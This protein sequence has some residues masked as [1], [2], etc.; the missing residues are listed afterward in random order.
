MEKTV[1]SRALRR[2]AEILGGDE[3]L[4]QQLKCSARELDTRLSAVE[5]PPMDVFLKAVDII[6]AAPVLSKP[7]ERARELRQKTDALVAR[8][9][10]A[11]ERSMAIHQAIVERR[12]EFEAPARP[13]SALAF[14]QGKFEPRD[15]PAMVSA[16]LD[17]AV[18]ATGADMGNMQLACPDGLRIVAQ[19]GF[20][21]PFLDFFSL[22]AEPRCAC[23]AAFGTGQRVAIADVRSDALF[24]GTQ[25][26]QVVL[27]AGALAVQ[28]TPVVG[29]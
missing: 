24:A 29:A 2:A 17:A 6:S 4:R 28:S 7:A 14:L 10:A 8:A 9:A 27:D 22:V 18:A 1:Q 19:R 11:R 3:N 21:Q 13:R 25:A 15:G 23:G 26:G 20:T 16:A 5:K 12:L